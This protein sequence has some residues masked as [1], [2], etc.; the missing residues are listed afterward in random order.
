[1]IEHAHLSLLAGAGCRR[2]GFGYG[3]VVVRLR[4]AK[5][6]SMG[7]S[8]NGEMGIEIAMTRARVPGVQVPRGGVAR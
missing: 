7:R 1:M 5:G 4:A 6:G 2:V 8:Q 3:S